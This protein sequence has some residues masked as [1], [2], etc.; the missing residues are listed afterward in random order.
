MRSVLYWIIVIA[1]IYCAYSAGWF[2]S[3]MNYF[4]DS[5]KFSKQEKVIYEEDGSVT[6]VKYKN[7]IDILTGK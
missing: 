7:F 1:L 5:A 6:T 2:N 3:I 4:T